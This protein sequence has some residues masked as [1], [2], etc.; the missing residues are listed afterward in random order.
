MENFSR[1]DG[2]ANLNIFIWLDLNV[3]V[4]TRSLP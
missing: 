1:L 2:R 3:A 4:I